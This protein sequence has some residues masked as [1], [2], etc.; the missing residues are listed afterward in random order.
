M[1][2]TGR[3]SLLVLFAIIG[4][5]VIV[6][7]SL[8]SGESPSDATTGFLTALHNQDVK[9][10]VELS[11]VPPEAKA[12]L[13]QQ[14]EYSVNVANPTYRFGWRI[15]NQTV[16]SDEATVKIGMTPNLGSPGA[17]ESPYDL[18][19]VREDGKWKIEIFQLPRKIYPALPRAS[20]PIGSS[21][22]S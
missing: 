18:H 1:K 3:V 2:R 11:Y 6:I 22:R 4:V 19:L 13:K 12:T 9:R 16:S 21:T 10:L 7:L 5:I 17:F 15:I 20:R 14:W 8:F